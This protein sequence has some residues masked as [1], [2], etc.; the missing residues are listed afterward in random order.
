[1]SLSTRERVTPG[2]TSPPALYAVQLGSSRNHATSNSE[3]NIDQAGTSVGVFDSDTISDRPCFPKLLDYV[4][5]LLG[6]FR[7]HPRIQF[8]AAKRSFDRIRH[9]VVGFRCE[10]KRE[11]FVARLVLRHG[12]ELLGA[13]AVSQNGLN[14]CQFQLL[15][16]PATHIW[17]QL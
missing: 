10:H 14:V 2:P 17:H 11:P 15:G 7:L 3:L 8:R 5:W 12:A 16:P 6:Q 9:L 1:M 13:I 4:E